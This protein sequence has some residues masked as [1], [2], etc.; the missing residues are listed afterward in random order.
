MPQVRSLSLEGLTKRYGSLTAVDHVSFTISPGIVF[1]LLGPNGA[2][3]TTTLEM[4]EGL[5]RPDEGRIRY[6]DADLLTHPEIGRLTFG[7]QLQTSA[8]FDRLTVEETLALFRSFYPRGLGVDTLIERLDLGEK[9]RTDVRRLSGGQRQRLALAAALVNDP[10]VVFLDEPSSGL[11]PQARHHLWDTILSLKD[12]G[13][14]VVLTTHVMEEAEALS[15]RVVIL[16]H[17]KVLEEGSP[18][19]LIRRHLPG[20]VIELAPEVAIPKGLVIPSLARIEERTEA[21]A[22]VSEHLEETLVALVAWA[23]DAGV[24]LTGLRTRG[25]TLEDVF[26]HLTGRSLREE[27]A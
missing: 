5:V 18:A 21:T 11:D 1:S 20:A 13:R 12:E 24:P 23:K 25:A 2:G 16:D 27:D 3:K 14:T 7:V 4:V 8:F 22:L 19:E 10:E 9:R 17:G 26:L 15:D 6:G